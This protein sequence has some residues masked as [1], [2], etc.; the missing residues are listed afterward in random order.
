MVKSDFSFIVGNREYFVRTVAFQRLMGDT[1][2]ALS[3]LTACLKKVSVNLADAQLKL[4]ARRYLQV[5][6][7]GCQI[8]PPE[9]FAYPVPGHIRLRQ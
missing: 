6:P 2:L 9:P 4:R 3:K 1:R 5:L 7:S 8:L